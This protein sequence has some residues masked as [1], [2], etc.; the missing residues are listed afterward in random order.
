M[1]FVKT[2]DII[3]YVVTILGFRQMVRHWILIP[4]FW[5]FESLKPSLPSHICEGKLGLRDS[6]PQNAGIRIQC[7]TIWRKPNIVTTY[8]IISDVFTKCKCFFEIFLI[9]FYNTKCNKYNARKYQP[10]SLTVPSASVPRF[11]G[12]TK[13]VYCSRTTSFFISS[14]ALSISS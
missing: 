3:P 14:I 7:L 12:S 6:N 11:A 4:A 8:G 10:L 5:G 13:Y 1:H 9:F 2:S